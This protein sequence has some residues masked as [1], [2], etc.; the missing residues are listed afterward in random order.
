MTV[1]AVTKIIPRD[2]YLLYGKFTPFHS[3]HIYGM[4]VMT[5]IL[6]VGLYNTLG[7]SDTP[8]YYIMHIFTCVAM[9]QSHDRSQWR[10]L[11]LSAAP[12]TCTVPF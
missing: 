8:F 1:R 6:I 7:S 5:S 4:L 2:N 12:I 9:V 3:A 10:M 11:L